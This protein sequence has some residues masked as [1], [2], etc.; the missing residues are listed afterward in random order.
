[1][2]PFPPI[3]R[4]QLPRSAC[5]RTREA[6]VG[7]GR[8]GNESGV[9]WIG[10][11]GATSPVSAIV[12]PKGPGMIEAPG[13]WSVAPEL[14]AAVAAWAKPRGL[15]LLAVVHTHLSGVRPHL[16]HTDRTRGLKVPG[17]LAVI[18][19]SGGLEHDID[20][21]GWYVY[22][23]D[24]YRELAHGERGERIQLVDADVEY[25][26]VTAPIMEQTP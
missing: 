4:W 11:R 1:M 17:A 21:W 18:I 10:R 8:R 15:S 2:D 13:R 9:F 6:V 22:D 25:V 5:G 14:Y 26:T 19:P 3:E 20:A 24:G 23:G 16:S 7:A 12:F